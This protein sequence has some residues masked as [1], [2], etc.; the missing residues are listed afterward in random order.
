M[1]DITNLLVNG[2]LFSSPFAFGAMIGFAT[3][4]IWLAF[5][6]SFPAQ[7]IRR[8]LDGYLERVDV[9]EDAE[10]RKP[11]AGRVVLPLFRRF[12]RLLGSLAPKR[13]AEATQKMLLQA[14]NPGGLTML[15]FFGLRLLS[16]LLLGGGYYFLFGENVPVATAARNT[17]IMGGIG[18][19]VPLYWLRNRVNQRKY[20]IRR[21]LPDA[22]DML[23]IG[24]EAGLAFES[25]M[26]KVGEKW[27]NAL[28]REFR[29]AV[30][31]MRVGTPRDVALQRMAE[32]SGVQEVSTFVAVLLQS[33]QLG[34]SIAQVLH[35][36]AAQVRMKR[37]QRAEELAQ[38]A[39]VKMVFPLILF[40]FPAMFVVALGP[41][42]P[43]A[44]TFLNRLNGG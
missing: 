1:V 37:R 31:E 36:Q 44:I 10:M 2:G 35:A 17:L 34:V 27:N 39:S 38:Q 15:D 16:V 4:L 13:N 24:V 11:F 41:A 20:E 33:S 40:I 5:M 6:P 9:I 26:V 19:F 14:G 29:R 3:I 23:T 7:M 32:R 12:L 30:A 42:L 43:T 22:L 28:T 18:F 21:A 25:A 8:R